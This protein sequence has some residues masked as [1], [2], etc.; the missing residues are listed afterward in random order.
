MLSKMGKRVLLLIYN[1]FLI[2]N[3]WVIL[4]SGHLTQIKDRHALRLYTEFESGN[5]TLCE[6]NLVQ[7]FVVVICITKRRYRI[8]PRKATKSLAVYEQFYS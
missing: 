4:S 8:W 1:E 3:Y 7:N 6:L 2:L 5:V